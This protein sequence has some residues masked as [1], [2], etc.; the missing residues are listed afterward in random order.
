VAMGQWWGQIWPG[1]RVARDNGLG[2]PILGRDP[3]I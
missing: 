3:W 2:P 1:Q